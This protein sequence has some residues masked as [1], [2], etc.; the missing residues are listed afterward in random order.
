MVMA[1]LLKCLFMKKR[2]MEG[3]STKE[4]GIRNEGQLEFKKKK[5]SMLYPLSSLHSPSSNHSSSIPSLSLHSTQAQGLLHIAM[6]IKGR[7]VDDHYFCVWKEGLN[8]TIEDMERNQKVS[9][10]AQ[11]FQWLD[12][13]FQDLLNDQKHVFFSRKTKMEQGVI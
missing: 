1:K 7:K 6:E 11:S 8:F 9:I 13:E 2:T 12:R 3:R 4:E 10:P 5:V